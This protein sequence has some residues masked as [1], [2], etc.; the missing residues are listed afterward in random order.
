MVKKN[1]ITELEEVKNEVSN[2]NKL[3]EEEILSNLENRLDKPILIK[4]LCEELNMNEYEILGYINKLKDKSLNISF[5]GDKDDLKVAINNHPDYVKENVYKIEEDINE[6]TKVGFI[7]DLRFGSKSEQI[8]MLNE[9]YKNFAHDGVKYVV[10]TGN[11]IEG[12]YK[13][14]DVYEFGNSLITNSALGQADHLI[15]YF[16]KVEGIKTL[17][18][19]GNNDYK[20][21][22]K[23]DVGKYIASKR[24]DMIYLGPKNCNLY[25]NNVCFR[26]EN[27]NKKG[28]AYTISYPPRSQRP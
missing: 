22:K 21:S 20:C 27:L 1:K 19:T 10:I 9:M 17:F 25:F 7:S 11:L 13:N 2:E 16:P 8:A 18:I 4:T 23:L 12:E 24:D 14:N 3:T 28:E 6:T 5:I 26:V 15:E